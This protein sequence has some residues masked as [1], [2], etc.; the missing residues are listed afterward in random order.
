[1]FKRTPWKKYNNTKIIIDNIKFNSKLEANCYLYLKDIY[2][3]IEFEPCFELQSKFK[4]E[5]K[6]IRNIIYKSDF[7]ILLNNN[8][9]GVIEIKWFLTPEYK[10]KRKLFL[11]KLKDFEKEMNCELV[12]IEAK[13]LRDLKEKLNKI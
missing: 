3:I 10:L 11:Y 2:K 6:I 1:M 12:F 7:L 8:T 4:Y 13:S 5:W 9:Y